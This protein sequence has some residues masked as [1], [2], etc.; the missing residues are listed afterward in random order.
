MYVNKIGPYFNPHETYHYY[1]L[2]VCRP[3]IVSLYFKRIFCII[4][5]ISLLDGPLGMHKTNTALLYYFNLSFI[6]T[7]KNKLRNS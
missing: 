6:T 5:V 2:P 3:K 1:Q 7:N 4:C